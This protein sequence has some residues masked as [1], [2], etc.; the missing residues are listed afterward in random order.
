MTADEK[1]GRAGLRASVLRT[2]EVRFPVDGTGGVG[3]GS[4]VSLSKQSCKQSMFT[5]AFSLPERSL[6]G[7]PLLPAQLVSL[8]RT[9]QLCLLKITQ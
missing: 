2:H 6:W 3:S 8:L 5:S 1:R 4:Q 7:G 9:V